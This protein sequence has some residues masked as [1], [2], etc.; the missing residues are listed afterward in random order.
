MQRGFLTMRVWDDKDF[1][2]TTSIL[3]SSVLTL[4]IHVRTR[5]KYIG[6]GSPLKRFSGS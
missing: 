6:N 2:T 5:L 4:R 3:K 1:A